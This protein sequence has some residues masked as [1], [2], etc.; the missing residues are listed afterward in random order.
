MQFTR[1]H[2][3][4]VAV[5][6]VVAYAVS[7]QLLPRV[8]GLADP[9]PTNMPTGG[10]LGLLGGGPGRQIAVRQ[11]GGRTAQR[12]RYPWIVNIRKIT[13]KK[14]GTPSQMQWCTGFL[15][16]PT[17]VMSA[18]H[19]FDDGETPS[20][21]V[22][23]IGGNM[24]DGSDGEQ[25][26][27]KSIRVGGGPTRTGKD[28]ALLKLYT[29]SKNAKPVKV[30]GLNAK[31]D[32]TKPRSVWSAGYGQGWGG[33]RF[34]TLQINELRLNYATTDTLQTDDYFEGE[35]RSPCHGDSGGPL[36]IRG[37][38]P[39]KDV[40]IGIVSGG[41]G[42]KLNKGVCTPGDGDGYYARTSWVM[43]QLRKK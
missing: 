17:V 20:D 3:V 22:L 8:E 6:A 15:I 10:L 33:Q 34:S 25:R 28:W 30:D 24:T 11:A 35:R 36:F 40:V 27:C 37:S 41:D 39:S 31:I 43:S 9:D 38:D 18:D 12:G 7:R 14:D 42:K 13:K 5:L 16:S 26:A 2:L 23:Y 4:I 19:C 21:F 29:P 32:L 1:A